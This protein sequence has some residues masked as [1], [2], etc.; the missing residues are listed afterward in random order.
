MLGIIFGQK[1]VENKKKWTERGA[2]PLAALRSVIVVI[3][4]SLADPGFGRERRDPEI[5]PTAEGSSSYCVD[6][7]LLK[8]RNNKKSFQP[9]AYH[10]LPSALEG[11][12]DGSPCGSRG[13]GCSQVSQFDQIPAVTTCGNDLTERYNRSVL[14]FT[15]YYVTL[16][17]YRPQMKLRQR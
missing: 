15:L 9:R 11:E 3:A 16:C 7:K 13:G 1:M 14:E 6:V 8:L 12:L 17:F 5:F 10:P 2:W 4:A